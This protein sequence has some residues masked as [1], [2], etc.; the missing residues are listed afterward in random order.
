MYIVSLC[1]F[2]VFFS[3]LYSFRAYAQSKE[4]EGEGERVR[5]GEGERGREEERGRG[6]EGE[7]GRWG[8]GEM[9]RWGDGEM[10]RWGDGEMGR[11]GDGKGE[12]YSSQ[13]G[14]NDYQKGNADDRADSKRLDPHEE[15]CVALSCYQ[16]EHQQKD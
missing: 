12:G 7:R 9:G 1:H 11:W 3:S 10:G 13:Y 2:F 6:G 4:T 8:D 14:R 16:G 15:F 5:G